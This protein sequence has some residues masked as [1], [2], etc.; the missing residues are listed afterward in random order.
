M[1]VSYNKLHFPSTGW[2]VTKLTKLAIYLYKL[3][4][5]NKKYEKVSQCISNTNTSSDIMETHNISIL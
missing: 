5:S 2:F 4:S 1:K 3:L